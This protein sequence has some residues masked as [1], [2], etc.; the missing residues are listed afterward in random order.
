MAF[1][2]YQYSGIPDLLLGLKQQYPGRK[3][4]LSY[5][6]LAAKIGYNSP[7]L[8]AMVINRQRLPS[9]KL[10]AKLSQALDLNADEQTYLDLL[11]L[12]EKVAQQ[13]ADSREDIPQAFLKEI[14]ELENHH[15]IP[16]DINAEDFAQI[17]EWQY[18]VIKQ[19]LDSKKSLG[20]VEWLEKKLGHHF[21]RDD[22]EASLNRMIELGI[23]EK[24]K[25]RYSVCEQKLSIETTNDIPSQA[26]KRHHA[27]ALQCAVNALYKSPVE[28]REFQTLVLRLKPE[29]NAEA[30]K[31]IRSFVQKFR[32]KFGDEDTTRVCRLNINLIEHTSDD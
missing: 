17:S 4:A 10:I 16:T 27:Q 9:E 15:P 29:H 7:R 32:K 18:F 23:V 20:T 28:N 26:I 12:K 21:G 25:Q 5:E 30:K 13:G 24:I 11:R 22:I 31:Y 3:T 14:A 1:S 8:F 19:L 6:Q 2:V